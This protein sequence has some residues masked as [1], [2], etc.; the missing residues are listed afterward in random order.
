MVRVLVPGLMSL[1]VVSACGETE[2]EPKASSAFAGT[3]TGGSAGN[4]AGSAGAPAQAGKGGVGGSSAVTAAVAECVDYCDTLEFLLPAALCEDWNRAGWDP[5]FCHLGPTMGCSDYC[6]QVFDT[7]DPAC[8]DTI[9]AVMRCV[10]PT[11]AQLGVPPPDQCWLK[12][13]RTELF[14][15]TSACYGLREKLAAA[16]AAWEASGITDYELSYW[17]GD[18]VTAR[19][20][21]RSGSEPTVMPT[22]LVAWTVPKL[23]AEVQRYLDEPGS[24]AK[25]E[26]DPQLGYV[27]SLGVER[28]CEE[29]PIGVASQVTVTPLSR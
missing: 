22:N 7:V 16:R 24:T 10:S 9:P 8:A 12:D 26:Y 19:V 27:V 17:F 25:A 18:D 28:G 5:Q 23:F 11:Y 15:M 13:C 3:S 2:R 1:F 14:T 20:T 4:L 21:V 6:T 29:Y